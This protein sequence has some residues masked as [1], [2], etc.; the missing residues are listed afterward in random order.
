M[1]TSCSWAPEGEM[2]LS[3]G[4]TTT[5]SFVNTVAKSGVPTGLSVPAGLTSTMS[6]PCT[7]A[8]WPSL[9]TKTTSFLPISEVWCVKVTNP[10][11]LNRTRSPDLGEAPT[12]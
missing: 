10:S 5:V 4:F 8:P 2:S 6:V 12:R 1:A 3:R 7:C 11:G 9:T